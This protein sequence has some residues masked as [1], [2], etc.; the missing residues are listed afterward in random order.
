MLLF[1]PRISSQILNL[2]KYI[3]FREKFS[4]VVIYKCKIFMIYKNKSQTYLILFKYV[5]A[6]TTIKKL[7]EEEEE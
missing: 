4:N 1:S 7:I 2:I 3:V 5:V 6:I